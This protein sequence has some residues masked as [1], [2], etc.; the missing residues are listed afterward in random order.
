MTRHHRFDGQDTADDHA[1]IERQIAQMRGSITSR[2]GLRGRVLEEASESVGQMRRKVRSAKVTIMMSILL[3]VVSPLIGALTRIEPP[4]PQT[5][6]SA[7]AAALPH[8]EA[9]RMSFDWALVDVFS[10]FRAAKRDR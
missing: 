7:N 8:A 9:G 6:A 2:N 10:Q 1:F 3:V 5:A 4:A